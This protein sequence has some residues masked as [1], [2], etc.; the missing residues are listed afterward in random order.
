MIILDEMSVNIGS[1]G[2]SGGGQHMEL[3]RQQPKN[4]EF[5][6]DKPSQR[7]QHFN[8]RIVFIRTVSCSDAFYSKDSNN[9]KSDG[10]VLSSLRVA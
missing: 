7:R 10:E 3:V 8:L 5:C 1:T 6:S 9:D 4:D 2:L